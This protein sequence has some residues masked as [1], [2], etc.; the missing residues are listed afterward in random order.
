MISVRKFLS[1]PLATRERKLWR[2]LHELE[3]ALRNGD[4]QTTLELRQFIQSMAEIVALPDSLAIPWGADDVGTVLRAVNNLRHSIGQRIGKEA[5]EWDLFPPLG[6]DSLTVTDVVATSNSV[7]PAT[8]PCRLVYCDDIRSPFNLG[9]IFRTAW[10]F[11]LDGIVLSAHC[12]SPNH[13]RCVRSAMGACAMVPWIR[14][15]GE[16]LAGFMNYAFANHL[17]PFA[18]ELGGADISGFHFPERGLALIGSEELGVTPALLDCCKTHGGIVT[19]PLSGSKASL[20]VGVSFGA[21]SMIWTG[22]KRFY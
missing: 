15:P 18:L 10:A 7:A 22:V 11:G 13:P 16:G 19:I 12:P 1:L 5:A 6:A 4:V 8:G 17:I 14:L 20:N 21:L 3:S 9:S 2:I